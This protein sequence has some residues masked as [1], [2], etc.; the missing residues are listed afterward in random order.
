MATLNH[1]AEWLC[2]EFGGDSETDAD[3]LPDA[4]DFVTYMR[5]KGIELVNGGTYKAGQRAIKELNK[6]RKQGVV[7]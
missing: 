3:Y 6:L 4:S 5:A 2:D 7:K 1:V